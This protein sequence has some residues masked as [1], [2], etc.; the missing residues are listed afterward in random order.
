MT[1]HNCLT[2]IA[3]PSCGQ[4][5]EFFIT[6]TIEVWMSDDGIDDDYAFKYGD[7]YEWDNAARIRCPECNHVN[8]V[9]TFTTPR[10]DAASTC[11]FCGEPADDGEGYDGF[12]GTC[13]D[14]IE[15]HLGGNHSGRSQCPSCHGVE[16]H[17]C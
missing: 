8:T 9:A 16:V 5:D 14:L 10:Q 13:A 12:C 11:S 4:E 3:C 1:N 6:C 17:W 7:G 15:A 2:G